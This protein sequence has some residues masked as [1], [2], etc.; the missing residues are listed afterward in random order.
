MVWADI[1]IKPTAKA[2][3]DAY[4]ASRMGQLRKQDAETLLKEHW[5]GTVDEVAEKLIRIKNEGI[6]HVVAMHTATD[7]YEEMVEQ[8][9]LFAEEVMPLVEGA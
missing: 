5:I 7:T 8:T 3:A 9:H 2:G 1:S 4:L 6:D